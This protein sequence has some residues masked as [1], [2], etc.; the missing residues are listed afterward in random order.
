M[1]ETIICMKEI[2]KR[3]PGV[4]A[5]DRANL[6]IR[7]GEIHCIVGEN[8]AGKTTLM[9]ILYGLFPPD[10]GEIFLKG[11]KIKFRGP[12]D[13]INEKIGMVHQEFMLVP[14]I[15]TLENIMLGK[16]P[17]RKTL[18]LDRKKAK[19]EIKKLIE[20]FTLNV[21]LE[22]KVMNLSVSE[23][24]KAEILKVLFRGAEVIILDEPTAVLTPQEIEGL[25]QALKLLKS[26]NKTI[27][28][29]THKLKEVMEIADRVTVMRK[30]KAVGVFPVNEVS[31]IQLANLIIGR[32]VLFQ[33]E[34]RKMTPGKKLLSVR[35]L[36]VKNDQGLYFV[37]GIS[38]DIYKGEIIGIAAVSGNG[39]KEL[40][41][42]LFGLRRIDKGLVMLNGKELNGLSVRKIMESG[43]AYIPAD[44]DLTGSV[45]EAQVWKNL[46]A[47]RHWKP[48][49]SLHGILNKSEINKFSWAIINSFGIK[50]S[51][52]E[53]PAKTLSGGNLQRL[54]VGRELSLKVDIIIAENPTRGL[55]I[56]ATEY[57]RRL[58]L[59]Y[60]L[61]GASVLLLSEDL[62]EIMMI[63]DRILVM[64]NGKISG[65]KDTSQTTKQEIGAL[66]LGEKFK[67]KTSK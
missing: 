39:Q 5:L 26:R 63:T 35:D 56:G 11:K 32:G 45:S 60:E 18:L 14:S 50:I 27:L 25:F 9:N 38:F 34:K 23:K 64:Y 47:G 53:A 36:W 8:G 22:Q 16:E 29:I 59:E 52:L 37:K 24:Q 46:I 2:T 40:I 54:I 17:S 7:K 6:S 41:E 43:L 20:I 42:A 13:A 31:E 21:P 57:V 30:G 51:S 4:L 49:L 44:R 66:M 1:E 67:V 55:D 33:L 12:I 15:S 61:T 48:P 19:K 28:F 58:I 62:D 10:S 3:F 65:E